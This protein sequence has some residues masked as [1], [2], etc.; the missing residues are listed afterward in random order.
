M[1]G[2]GRFLGF[3]TLMALRIAVDKFLSHVSTASIVEFR[4]GRKLVLQAVLESG[5]VRPF[6]VSAVEES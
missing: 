2:R 6:E 1:S 4:I 3:A 5:P